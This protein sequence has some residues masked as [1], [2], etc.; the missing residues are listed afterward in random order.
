MPS[1]TSVD[2]HLSCLSVLTSLFF[3]R[4]FQHINISSSPSPLAHTATATDMVAQ[5]K[6]VISWLTVALLISCTVVKPTLSCRISEFMCKS[7][8]GCVQLDEYCDGKYDCPDRSDEPPS[9]TGMYSYTATTRIVIY[10]IEVEY[11][12]LP[13]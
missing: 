2:D 6:G 8:G 5:A 12:G 1:Y 11:I 9:C 4:Y 10:N 7:T 3:R 13:V